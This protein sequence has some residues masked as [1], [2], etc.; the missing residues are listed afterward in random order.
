M[1]RTRSDSPLFFDLLLKPDFSAEERA[2]AR[3]QWPVAGTDEAGRGPLAG[4]VVAAAVILDPD[5]IPAGLDDSK[6]LSHGQREAAYA[7][8]IQSALSVS[9]ASVC[10]A[11]IDA[12]DIRKA[13]LEAM[14]RAVAGLSMRPLLVLADGRD[15]PPGLHCEGAALVK[16]DQRSQSIAAASILAKVARDRMLSHCGECHPSYGFERHAGYGTAVHLRGIETHGAIPGL[17]RMSFA[18]LR[19]SGAVD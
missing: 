1:A 7:V 10:A 12:S 16:G 19:N 14:R 17:H 4:P 18:P 2:L 6:R 11:S 3:G 9:I 13:S 15:I 8:I 5:N